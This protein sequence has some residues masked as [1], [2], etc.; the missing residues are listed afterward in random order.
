MTTALCRGTTLGKIS[1]L[2]NIHIHERNVLY[3]PTGCWWTFK[4]A[5]MSLN[6]EGP[7]TYIHKRYIYFTWS[8]STAALSH[9]KRPHSQ[10][11][12]L[13]LSLNTR[14]HLFPCKTASSLQLHACSLLLP[15]LLPPAWWW[16]WGES[17]S[18]GSTG[19]VF[20][21]PI[22]RGSSTEPKTITRLSVLNQLALQKQCDGCHCYLL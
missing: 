11:I 15:L 6:K 2:R 4:C 8:L 13:F 18:P 1:C 12:F 5:C 10:L 7:N 22:Q 19:S 21:L 16:W 14:T 20:R 9:L 3:S 17:T